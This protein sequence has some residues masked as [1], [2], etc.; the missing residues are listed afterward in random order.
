M[1]YIDVETFNGVYKLR[2]PMGRIGALHFGII[3]KFMPANKK[4]EGDPISP[5]EQERIG[6]GFEEW[7]IKILPNILVSFTPKDAPEAKT[8]TIDEMTGEDQ[9]SMFLAV[10]STMEA[11]ENFFRIV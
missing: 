5:A 8:I 11:S 6:Q 7:S 2:K 4:A 1:I 3:T 9:Y 10:C